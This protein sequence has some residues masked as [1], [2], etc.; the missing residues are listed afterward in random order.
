MVVDT[1]DPVA[2]VLAQM[3]DQVVAGVDKLPQTALLD[4]E[5]Y[6]TFFHQHKEI[7]A[8]EVVVLLQLH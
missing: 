7:M 3:V 2:V 8:V 1:A 5:I 4:Q 6:P